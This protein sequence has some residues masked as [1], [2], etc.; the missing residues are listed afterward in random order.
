MEIRRGVRAHVPRHNLDLVN[1]LV[2]SGFVVLA[3]CPS[4]HQRLRDSNLGPRH[5]GDAS[6]TRNLESSSLTTFSSRFAYTNTFDVSTVSLFFL[7]CCLVAS[8]S[9][10]D[11]NLGLWHHGRTAG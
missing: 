11:S 2:N 6:G 8:Q 7:F 5:N 1:K 3:R 9:L 10:E 4:R